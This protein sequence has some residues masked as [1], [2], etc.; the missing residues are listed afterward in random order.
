[1]TMKSGVGGERGGGREITMTRPR[2]RRGLTTTYMVEE[3][4]CPP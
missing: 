4:V 3:R 1:M 2:E